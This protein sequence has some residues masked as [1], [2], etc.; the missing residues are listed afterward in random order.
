MMDVRC[1]CALRAL[2]LLA[3]VL[4][5][6]PGVGQ[7]MPPAAFAAQRM[8]D[9][10]PQ[11]I[12]WDV[13]AQAVGKSGQVMTGDVYRIAMPRTDLNVAVEGV[14]VKP[15]FALGSYAAFKQM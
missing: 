2:G 5:L 1:R 13:V 14:P 12:D 15:G 3:A 11:A 7:A 4:L 6:G 8:P 10:D 9:A